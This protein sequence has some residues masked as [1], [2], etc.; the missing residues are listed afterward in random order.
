MSLF[1]FYSYIILYLS[2]LGWLAQPIPGV[3]L[4]LQTPN[5]QEITPVC[6]ARFQLFA[7]WFSN[8]QRAS[9]G[10]TNGQFST[11]PTSCPGHLHHHLLVPQT[12][13]KVPQLRRTARRWGTG[14][15]RW[16]LPGLENAE[17]IWHWVRMNRA[18]EPPLESAHSKF[19]L[20]RIAAWRDAFAYANMSWMEL[21]E[22][23]AV[24]Y[25]GN[26]LLSTATMACSSLYHSFKFQL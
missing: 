2:A 13:F 16:S 26:S 15:H 24:C 21:H 12:G 6:I 11:R 19:G 1:M 18:W 10:F 14:W 3:A 7:H 20:H 9:K 4:H 5:L 23:M 17:D 22:C 8:L 25:A